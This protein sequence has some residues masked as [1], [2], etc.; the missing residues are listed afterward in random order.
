MFSVKPSKYK[1]SNLSNNNK[2]P[3]ILNK[4][5]NRKIF[6]LKKEK[7]SLSKKATDLNKIKNNNINIYLIHSRNEIKNNNKSTINSVNNNKNKSNSNKRYYLGKSSKKNYKVF[8][9]NMNQN[10]VNN[11]NKSENKYMNFNDQIKFLN[12][13]NYSVKNKIIFEKNNLKNNKN[14]NIWISKDKG[15]NIKEKI[16]KIEKFDKLE[17]KKK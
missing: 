15:L 14:K 7:H 3:S 13:P 11:N 9:P 2:F 5:S 8:F 6:N 4:E 10:R 12:N 17:E 1:Q 16:I